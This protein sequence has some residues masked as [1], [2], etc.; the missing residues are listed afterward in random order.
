MPYTVGQLAALSG[1]SVRTLHHYDQIGLLSPNQRSQSGYRLYT[2]EDVARLQQI[3]FYRELGM[4][5]EDLRA[6]LDAPDFDERA[7]LMRHREQLLL[8]KQRLDTLLENIDRTLYALEGGPNMSDKQRLEGF[9]QQLVEENERLYGKEIRRK[10]GRKA[11]EESN[12]KVAAMSKG[13][14][15]AL[16]GRRLAI[17]DAFAAAMQN[18]AGSDAAQA[19]AG[20]YVRYLSAFGTY[21]LQAIRGLGQ[22]YV[23]DERF[24]Q[25]FDAHTPGLAAFVCDALHAYVDVQECKQ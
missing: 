10:Y 23:Q 20:D 3:L 24:T 4:A 11:V 7:A 21:S 15:E 16:E 18:G 6:I 22:M 9:G 13:D 25:H 12:A 2:R 14:W 8:R 1:V 17:Y 5:L 19:A